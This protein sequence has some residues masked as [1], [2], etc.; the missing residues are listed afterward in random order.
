MSCA[1]SRKI[2]I[3][4]IALLNDKQPWP[5]E[6]HHFLQPETGKDLQKKAGLLGRNHKALNVSTA[7]DEGER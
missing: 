1:K 3:Y 4:L 5:Q 7:V 2:E 6:N